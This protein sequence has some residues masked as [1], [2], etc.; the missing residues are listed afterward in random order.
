MSPSTHTEPT[1]DD[2]T[3]AS[4]SEVIGGPS[5]RRMIPSSWWTPVRVAMAIAGVV[6]VLGMLHEVPCAST[7]WANSDVRYQHM[8]YSDLPYL[9]V[10]RGLAE[11]KVPYTDNGGRYNDMEYPVV[12]GYFAYGTAWITHAIA[13]FPDLSL[14]HQAPSE[15]VGTLP[16]VSRESVVFTA[17]SAV[18]LGLLSV[19]AAGFLAG[20]HRGRPWDAVYYAA[21]P[22]VA[23]SGLV[24][25]DIL[26]VL[27]VA[28]AFWAWARGRPV[29]AGVMI[30][31]GTA[32]KLYPLFLLGALLIVAVRRR[33]L[34]RWMQATVAAVVAW[35]VVNLPAMLTAF[36][37]WKTFWVFNDHRG[38]DL[39]SVWMLASQLGFNKD[40]TFINDVSLIFFI[41][42]C[43]LV[44]VLG[45]VVPH[46]PRIAQLAFL[47]VAGF[48]LINKVYSPQYV[49]WLLPLAALA[50][51]R[52]KDLMI[53][54]AG[55]I[56]YFAAVWWM[57][58]SITAPPSGD[59]RVYQVAIVVR[60]LAELY[61]MVVVVRDIISPKHDHARSGQLGADPMWPEIAAARA[62]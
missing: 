31:L 59:D 30:G 21:A 28:I 4:A 44:L 25:W 55:E 56:F 42:V 52:W 49:L 43:L 17:V 34:G 39:G 45:L 10:G 5:G 61:L 36:S 22:S 15:Q 57:L 33:G 27:C 23:L 9:Y 62:E 41:G 18:L 13:G 3:L 8:C 46:P 51:P 29:L 16:G 38:A 1:H 2:P 60:I 37:H 48:L 47:I 24:N 12:I 35:L 19:V 26:A 53:W 11:L 32:T 20:A 54:Q 6:W 7:N 40:A 58:G 14:R 50:R